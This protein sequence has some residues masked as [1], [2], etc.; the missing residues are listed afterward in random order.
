MTSHIRSHTEC[1]SKWHYSDA[2]FTLK[3]DFKTKPYWRIF[4]TI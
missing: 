1:L 3:F 2:S 4:N